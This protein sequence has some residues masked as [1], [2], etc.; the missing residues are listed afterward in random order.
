MACRTAIGLLALTLGSGGCFGIGN[1]L[2]S[3][4]V[5]LGAPFEFEFEASSQ[6]DLTLW[7]RYDMKFRGRDFGISGPLTVEPGSDQFLELTKD[8][9]PIRGRTSSTKS[10]T[11]TWTDAN[12]GTESSTTKLLDL[13]DAAAGDRIVIRGNWTAEPSTTVEQLRLV[14]AD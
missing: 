12:G 1:E 10:R 3:Y 14:V 13:G 4:D 9:Y 5:P 6:T 8:G 2:S 11:T 7:L